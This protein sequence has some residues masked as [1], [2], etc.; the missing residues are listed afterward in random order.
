MKRKIQIKNNPSCMFSQENKLAAKSINSMSV[1]ARVAARA[2]RA[3]GGLMSAALITLLENNVWKYLFR[4]NVQKTPGRDAPRNFL[5]PLDFSGVPVKSICRTVAAKGTPA[6][7]RCWVG[8]PWYG[9]AFTR[10]GILPPPRRE[11]TKNCRSSRP[12]EFS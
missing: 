1:R 3:R 5:K 4:S 6:H 2:S 8:A 7:V 10:S 12:P 11:S 9:S